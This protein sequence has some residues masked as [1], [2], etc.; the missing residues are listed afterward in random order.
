[1]R[2]G[3]RN[4]KWRRRLYHYNA[5]DGVEYS[6]EG[7]TKWDTGHGM[8]GHDC[9]ARRTKWLYPMGFYSSSGIRGY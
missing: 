4:G 8:M 3:N 5:W 7:S 6:W 2:G 9:I 1:V